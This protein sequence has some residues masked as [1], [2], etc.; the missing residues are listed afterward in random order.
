MATQTYNLGTVDEGRCVW[1]LDW[2][3]VSLFLRTIRC[4]NNSTAASRLTATVDS[5][6]RTGSLTAPPNSTTIQN[7]P[8]GAQTRLDISFDSTRNRIDG[9]NYQIFWPSS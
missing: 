6:G 9:V 7:L 4:K 3:D 1:E 8:T 5:N 2:D